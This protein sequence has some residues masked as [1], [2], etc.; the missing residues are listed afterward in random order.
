M[1][2]SELRSL[3]ERLKLR[4]GYIVEKRNLVER[5]LESGKVD[6]LAS[7]KPLEYKLSQLRKMGVGKLRKV[8][9]DGGVFYDSSDVVEKEDMV[10]IFINSGR[11][12]LLEET[13]GHQQTQ[14]LDTHQRVEEGDNNHAPCQETI[15][16]DMDRTSTSPSQVPMDCHPNPTVATRSQEYPSV[17]METSTFASRSVSELKALG[18]EFGIDLSDC[19]EK[20][21][22][23]QKIVRCIG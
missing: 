7:P 10:Q 4:H 6:V 14:S 12:L 8:M 13:K 9:N 15:P 23:V 18:R 5:V 16:M 22:M 17:T 20:S 21:E 3:C 19:L 2:V 11:V 1:S